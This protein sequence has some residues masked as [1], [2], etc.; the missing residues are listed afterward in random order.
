M[1]NSHALA[2][3]GR[4]AAAAA[5][6]AAF[7]AAA[8]RRTAVLITAEQGCG[9]G[10][11]SRRLHDHGP[12]NAA[13]EAVDCGTRG[14]RELD[15]LLFGGAAS[16]IASNGLET[17][18]RDCA[19][20]RLGAGTL[21]LENVDQ[22][23]ASTQRRLARVMRDAEVRVSS[24]RT[25]VVADFR[26]IGTTSLDLQAEARE[27]R[28]RADLLRRLSA[29]RIDLLPLRRRASDIADIVTALPRVNAAISAPALTVLTSLPW[30]GNI[31]E[32]AAFIEAL[33]HTAAPGE[34]V[35][36]EEVLRHL[37]MQG[38]L[39][40][41]DLTAGLRE[42]RRQFERDYIAAVLTRHGWSMSDAARTLG[43]ERANLYRKTR[44]LGITRGSRE[45]WTAHR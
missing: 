28:F 21:V 7:G 45:P 22:L 2:L 1:Q 12:T 15:R 35:S 19:I 43:I 29:S 32:L 23:P 33:D 34:L 31:D 10:E 26:L 17:V 27:G 41:P 14:A 38:S 42:A 4:S 6:R 18:S 40:R 36:A 5:A 13:F 39:A 25:P 20:V 30:P 24:G 9:A 37:P 11:L 3:V 8:V 44:Q 16:N